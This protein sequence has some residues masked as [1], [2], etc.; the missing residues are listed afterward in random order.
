VPLTLAVLVLALLGAAAPAFADDQRVAEL[1]STL[2]QACH[3]VD[4]NSEVGMFPKLAGQQPE[5]LAR[6]LRDY[7]QGRRRNE[8]MQPLLPQIRNS[9]IGR[10]AVWYGSQTPKAGVVRDAALAEAGRRLYE[11]GN[12]DT[13]VPACVGCHEPAGEGNARNPRLA[14]QHAEYIVIE[15]GKFRAGERTNDRGG[16]MRAVAQRLSEAEIQAVAEYLTGL[17]PQAPATAT[18]E[19]GAE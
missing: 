16:I 18:A 3:G 9:D 11:D 8:V 6:Q 19:R 5:Y 12:E 17:G 15:M 2:C 1:T 4:G 7:V 13:G 14:G 10:L